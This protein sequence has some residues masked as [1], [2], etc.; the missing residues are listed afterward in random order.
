[1]TEF[2]VDKLFIIFTLDFLFPLSSCEDRTFGS[3]DMMISIVSRSSE[4]NEY[5]E[6]K[7][8]EI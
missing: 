8:N 7:T 4:T 3:S 5:N 1:M 2:L 6:R